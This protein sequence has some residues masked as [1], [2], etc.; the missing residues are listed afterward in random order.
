[1]KSKKALGIA[2]LLV[3]VGTVV[4]T[5]IG[6]F[7]LQLNQSQST[8]PQTA[9]DASASGGTP[10][11][12][13]S[14]PSLP[15]GPQPTV[16]N[17]LRTHQQR[18]AIIKNGTISIR[19]DNYDSARKR[20]RKRTGELGGYVANSG[21]TLNGH[22]NRTWV[23]GY[24][25]LRVPAEQFGQLLR[26]TKQQGTVENEITASTDVS[27]KLVDL[28]ARIKNLKSKRDR[29]RSFYEE[30][31]DTDDLLSVQERLSE[32]QGE[33]EQLEAKR[34]A[35]RDRVGFSTLRVEIAEPTPPPA[36]T[37]T[38]TPEPAYHERSVVTAFLSSVDG[39]IVMLRT[40]L[41]TVSYLLPYLF[42]FVVAGG[43]LYAVRKPAWRLV[44]DGRMWVRG[45]TDEQETSKRTDRSREQ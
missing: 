30:A 38:P 27:G 11:S 21:R 31:N 20:L 32:V 29:L 45:E 5:V 15:S 14:P 37:P 19:V 28:N 4:L 43:V 24:V 26:Y 42:V 25:V 9:L 35:L 33:I 13:G 36:A 23:T 3:V 10:S 18:A 6:G 12:S 44:I 40:G 16:E 8:A 2:I 1:M 34:R 17:R 22:G 41:V 7:V 39:V